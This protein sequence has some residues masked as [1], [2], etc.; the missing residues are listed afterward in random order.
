MPIISLDPGAAVTDPEECRRL[1][2]WYR[3][4]RFPVAGY[5]EVQRGYAPLGSPWRAVARSRFY[6]IARVRLAWLEHRDRV[7]NRRVLA[8]VV[9]ENWAGRG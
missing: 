5:Y 2:T 6:L 3:I 7:E 4:V 8:R 1:S 9:Y